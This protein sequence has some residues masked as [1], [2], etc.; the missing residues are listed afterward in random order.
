MTK[1]AL[2]QKLMKRALIATATPLTV[3]AAGNVYVNDVGS[4]QVLKLAAA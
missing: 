1:T 4:H 2:P 3:D